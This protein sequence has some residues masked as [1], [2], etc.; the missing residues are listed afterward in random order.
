MEDLASAAAE[1]EAAAAA[2]AGDA[3]GAEPPKPKRAKKATKLEMAQRKVNETT[4]KV[5]EAEGVIASVAGKG[6]MATQRERKKAKALT[7]KLDQMRADVATAE[8]DLHNTTEQAKVAA[9]AEQA[10]AAARIEK[11]EAG[12]AMTEGGLML[13]VSTRISFQ[14]RF[15]NSSDTAAACWEAVVQKYVTAARREDMPQSDWG[16]GVEAF[17]KL[18]TKY[19][20]EAKL[21]SA[22]AQRAVSFSGVPADQVEEWVHEHYNC[23]TSLFVKAGL[24]NK[25]MAQ[26]P[27]QMSGET[28]AMGG[29]G[30]VNLGLGDAAPTAYL[31]PVWFGN[32]QRALL[33]PFL[34]PVPPAHGPWASPGCG[35]LSR[36]CCATRARS[37]RGGRWRREEDDDGE[38]STLLRTPP[39]AQ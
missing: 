14:S 36:Q 15:D 39:S 13:F 11:E 2:D 3:A 24:C 22:K 7:E 5:L 17:K 37:S 23:T 31:D 4:L 18:W 30:A 35:A 16:R 21:W 26:P 25:P 27:F 12:R 32:G 10:K 33:N 20:G 19:W 34:V 8:M 29:L 6:A 38:P 1:S 9:A 28:A